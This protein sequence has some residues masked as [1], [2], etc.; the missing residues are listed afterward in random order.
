M[1]AMSPAAWMMALR[2]VFWP[3][4]V[5]RSPPVHTVCSV[6]AMPLTCSAARTTHASTNSRS[7][8]RQMRSSRIRLVPAQ[9]INSSS[10]IAMNSF[11]TCPV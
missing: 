2:F 10:A 9:K 5:T 7:V 1:T 4:A 8:V 6:V 11:A 3:K